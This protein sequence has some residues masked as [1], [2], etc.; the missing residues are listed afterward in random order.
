MSYIAFDIGGTMIKY[1][2]VTSDNLIIKEN[3]VPTYAERGG[4]SIITRVIELAQ[5]LLE[6]DDQHIEGI[7]IATAGQVNPYTGEILYA[8]DAIPNYRHLNIV[9]LIQEKINLPVTVEN[10]VN[11][12]LLA[13][14]EAEQQGVTALFTVGTG[15][16]GAVAIDNHIVHGKCF[17]AGEIG[18]LPMLSSTFQ[19]LASTRALIRSVEKHLGKEGLTGIEVF[20]LAKENQEIDTII[21]RFFDILAQ[22]LSAPILLLSCQRIILGG[23]ILNQETFIIRLTEKLALYIPEHILSQINLSRTKYKNNSGMIG[24]VKWYKQYRSLTN[25]K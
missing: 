11:C 23:A 5:T 21:D 14:L 24:A 15:I 17:S 4:Y 25:E 19:E 1:G 12:A 6:E 2:I 13:E 10:D 18:Y 3:Q 9:E 22:G 7:A 20:E 8:S 16:G